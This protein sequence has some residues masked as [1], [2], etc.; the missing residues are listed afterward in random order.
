[1]DSAGKHADGQHANLVKHMLGHLRFRAQDP[2]PAPESQVVS[3]RTVGD[4]PR[5]WEGARGEG[6]LAR[7]LSTRSGES[8]STPPLA[9]FSEK[10]LCNLGSAGHL[11]LRIHPES[12]GG[13]MNE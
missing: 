5:G 1:M 6:G 8:A 7:L 2:S 3:L 9:C 4:E 11:M 13:G 12:G 10:L